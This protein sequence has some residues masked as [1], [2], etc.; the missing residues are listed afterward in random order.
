M[1]NHS[2]VVREAG[3]QAVA[4]ATE[5]S[6]HTVHS[7]VQRGRIPAEHWATFA[8]HGWSTLDELAQ[9]AASKAA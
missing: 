4:D 5:V 1:R 3:R 7:W 9:A 8:E 2:Q 6:I